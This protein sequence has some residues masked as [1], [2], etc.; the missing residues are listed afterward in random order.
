M[1]PEADEQDGQGNVSIS[2]AFGD[3]IA[4]A[5]DE[6]R[7]TT[8]LEEKYKHTGRFRRSTGMRG[9]ASRYDAVPS[10]AAASMTGA[11]Q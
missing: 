8:D 2:R 9:P 5:L 6:G 1:D 4:R 3:A 10:E 7:H 11:A